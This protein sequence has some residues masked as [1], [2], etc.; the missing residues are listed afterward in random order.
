MEETKNARRCEHVDIVYL[1][2]VFIFWNRMQTFNLIHLI[3]ASRRNYYDYFFPLYVL[4]AYITLRV[5]SL[6]MTK[7]TLQQFY[8]V[9]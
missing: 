9:T 5:V 1:E 3:S 6:P 2:L 7:A 4:R 8:I